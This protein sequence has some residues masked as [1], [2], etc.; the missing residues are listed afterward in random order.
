MRSQVGTEQGQGEEGNSLWTA[1]EM[2]L[3]IERSKVCYTSWAE[4]LMCICVCLYLFLHHF[5]SVPISPCLPF[6]LSLFISLILSACEIYLIFIALRCLG[7]LPACLP[8]LLMAQQNTFNYHPSNT[9]TRILLCVCAC[10]ALLSYRRNGNQSSPTNWNFLL[11]I[12]H[13]SPP[14]SSLFARIISASGATCHVAN[15]QKTN[16]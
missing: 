6:S 5:L 12:R 13:C 4:A 3:Q 2:R 1:C 14:F 7:C 10:T 11:A 8:A 15:C 9:H 16:K